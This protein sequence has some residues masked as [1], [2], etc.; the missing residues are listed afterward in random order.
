MKSSRSPLDRVAQRVR[1]IP[2]SGIRDF[3]DVVSRRPDAISLGVGEPGFPTPWHIRDAAVYA[4]ER[5]ATGYT[6]NLGLLELRQA[7]SR[8]VAKT[9]GVEYD[10]ETEILV[11]TGVSEAVDLA[12]RALVDPGDEVVYHEPCYVS[13]APVTQLAG[14]IPKVVATRFEEGFRLVPG[15]LE[16]VVG[17][18][19]KILLLNFPNNPTG[20]DVPREDLEAVAAIARERDLVVITDEIYAELTYEGSH[21]SIAALPGM[22]ERTLLLHGFSKA[23]AMTGFRLGY[24]CGPAAWIEAMMKIHQYT[25]L[26]APT[27]SQVAAVEALERADADVPEM[28]ERYRRNRNF[29]IAAFAEMGLPVVRP[30]GAFYAFPRISHLGVDSRTFAVQLLEEEDVAVVPGDAFGAAGAGYIRCS[31]ATD[32]EQIK[33]ALARMARFVEGLRRRVARTAS[34]TAL[35]QS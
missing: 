16:E 35:R 1:E 29:M 18:R 32:F 7:L 20:A 9:F 22:R 3:F 24:A 34:R 14:G 19:T 12:L 31:Y 4:L 10:P 26:C 15:R 28:R 11:T 2:R 8:Y 30:A 33:V 21:C 23:W 13:Y 5:G 17:D 6:S 27:L 25:M